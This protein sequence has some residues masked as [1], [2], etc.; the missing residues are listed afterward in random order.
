MY[1]EIAE[2][3]GGVGGRFVCAVGKKKIIFPEFDRVC[4]MFC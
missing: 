4:S 1:D 3:K 2:E